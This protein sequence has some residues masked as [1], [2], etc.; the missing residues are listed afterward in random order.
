MTLLAT[1][2]PN[3][4][5]MM[6]ED[7]CPLWTPDGDRVVFTSTCS[8]AAV[9]LYLKNADGTG[10]VERLMESDENQ[11]P[12]AWSA[13]GD[14]LVLFSDNDLHT[15]SSDSAPTSTPLLQTEFTEDRPSISH[16]GQWIAYDSNED[17]ALNVYVQ[18]FPNVGDGKWKVS[19]EG[20]F[21]PMWSP[22]G[23][24]LFYVSG[25][26]MMVVP[27]TSDPAFQHGNP[28]VVFEGPYGFTGFWS[29]LRPL[30]RWHAVPRNEVRRRTD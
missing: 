5:F 18:P 13:D 24:E 12:Y 20:G 3:P 4:R 9:S 11:I 7:F 6:P 30:A 8:G 16:D 28:A 21:H 19:T 26:A 27:I 10:A 17:G 2:S 15:W 25:I 14:T 22:D 1:I 29:I 23:D